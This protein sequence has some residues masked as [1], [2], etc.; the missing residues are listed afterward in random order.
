M[1][2]YLRTKE[3]IISCALRPGDIINENALAAKYDVGRMTIREALQ[4]LR[5]DGLIESVPR[6][7]YIV[8]TV[9]VKEVVDLF[10]VRAIVEPAAV[11][12][13]AENAT[14]EEVE[15]IQGLAKTE[16]ESEDDEIYIVLN[17]KNSE[18]HCAIAEAS[19]NQLLAWIQTYIMERLERV[20]NLQ[21]D[22][23]NVRDLIIE[24]HR[25]LAEAIASRDSERAR[26]IALA[27]VQV[28][29]Q[30]VIEAVFE[31]ALSSDLSVGLSIGSL[32]SQ[33]RRPASETPR[34]ST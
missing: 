7:G 6:V 8:S 1:D 19:H 34:D 23:T 21:L 12:A 20:L 2:P 17:R 18:F 22:A 11:A 13:A 15:R 32:G 33:G 30:R 28:S 27:Q 3:D 16:L 10:G 29:R 9:T 24:Q 31:G 14:A 5:H 26:E 4:A 25:P